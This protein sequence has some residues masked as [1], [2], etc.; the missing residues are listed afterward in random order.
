MPHFCCHA[1]CKSRKRTRP[2]HHIKCQLFSPMILQPQHGQEADAPKQLQGFLHCYGVPNFA[3]RG[4]DC[5][6]ASIVIPVAITYY[7]I[8]YH[9]RLSCQRLA[10][11]VCKHTRALH[12]STYSVICAIGPLL[13]SVQQ[14]TAEVQRNKSAQVFTFLFLPVPLNSSAGLSVRPEGH[15]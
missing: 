9:H 1:Y 6:A 3:H 5:F 2:L 14:A 15:L 12:T 8:I 7:R 4:R 10:F 11:I 13:P